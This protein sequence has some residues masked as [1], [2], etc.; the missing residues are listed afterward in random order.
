MDF[1]GMAMS[2]TGG[3]MIAGKWM[4]QHTGEVVTVRDSYMDGENMFVSLSN[5]RQLTMQEFQNYVQM[6]E[7]GGD[8]VE[9]IAAA[10]KEKKEKQPKYDPSLVFDG[11][12]TTPSGGMSA[13]QRQI[14]SKEAASL[15]VSLDE[16]A[17]KAQP[18]ECVPELSSGNEQERMIMKILDKADA[19]E[20]SFNVVWDN[21]PCSEL[22]V[23]KEYF[24]VTDADI[25]KTVIKKYVTKQDI[26]SVVT[27]WVKDRKI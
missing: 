23:L 20:L 24:G 25:A 16:D 15:G 8:T 10:A 21:C 26:D 13:L 5:G 22:A 6:S 17:P 27:E 14:L 19:P 11:I 9:Q 18:A 1:G 3:P 12:D 2:S 4:N 7:D